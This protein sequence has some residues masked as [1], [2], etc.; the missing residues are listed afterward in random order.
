LSGDDQI[1]MRDQLPL[2]AEREEGRHWS[3][4]LYCTVPRNQRFS[5]Y[6]GLSKLQIGDSLSPFLVC[7]SGLN[8]EFVFDGSE[9]TAEPRWLTGKQRYIAGPSHVKRLAEDTAQ[10]IIE[11]GSRWGVRVEMIHQLNLPFFVDTTYRIT[12]TLATVLG[13]WLGVFWAS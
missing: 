2:P 13:S 8:C 4:Q 5:G 12:P 11:P 1:Q 3:K 6:N 9:A 10:I 7:C